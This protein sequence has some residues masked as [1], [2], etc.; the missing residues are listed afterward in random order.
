MSSTASNSLA[1]TLLA[2]T[3]LAHTSLA[4]TLL[5]H[6]SLAHTHNA[7]YAK[8]TIGISHSPIFNPNIDSGTREWLLVLSA[9]ICVHCCFLDKTNCSKLKVG[10][11]CHSSAMQIDLPCLHCIETPNCLELCWNMSFD[12][13][14]TIT[15]VMRRTTDKP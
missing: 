7:S 15:S 13:V 4:H 11:A 8:N 12:D 6:T 5:A 3:S 1:H 2:H 10:P 9:T 14:T